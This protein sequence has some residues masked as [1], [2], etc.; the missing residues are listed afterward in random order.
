MSETF[1]HEAA[2]E[3]IPHEPGCYLMKDDRGR[4][5]YIGK[6]KD[7]NDRVHNYFQQSGDPRPFVA[8]LPMLLSDIDTIITSNEK[9]ALILE[10]T[11]IKR[12]Q[13]RFNVELKDDK[14][15]LSLRIDT[16]HEWP[17]V[18]VVRQQEDDGA[19]YFGPYSSAGAIRRTL[20][21]INK[22]FQL[23]SCPDTVLSN[24]DRPCLQHQI[25]RCPAPCVFALDRDEYMGQLEDAVMFLEGRGDDL[26][27]NIRTKMEEASED[28]E[29]ELAA[30]YRDQLHSIE[31]VLE[32][33]VAVNSQ[34]ID[35]DAIGYYREG[36]RLT[37][38]VVYL[39]DGRM[40]GA[41]SFNF[42]DQ[43]FPDEEILSSFLNQYYTGRSHIPK[44][45]LLPIEMSDSEQEAFEEILTDEAGHRVYIKTP[46]RGKKKALVET[47]M[48]NAEHSFESEHSEEE[49]KHDLMEKLQQGLS[50]NNF[51]ERIECYDISNLQGDQIVGS[52][53]YFERA[54]PE[55]SGYR[56][57]KIRDVDEQD[58]FASMRE[59]LM[60]R[61]RKVA[62]GEEDAPDLVVIDG[63]KGQ[64]AQASTVFEDLG[65]HRIDVIALAKSRTDRVGFEDPEVTQSPE[66]AF[67]PNRKNPIRLD[68]NSA[69]TYLLERL[70][71]EAHRF[72]I[73]YHKK[74]RRKETLKSSLDDVPG[75][76][77]KTKRDLLKHF[78]GLSKVKDAEIAELV[79]VDGVGES[80]AE[81]IRRYFNGPDV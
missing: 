51:P 54:E 33:Q 59:V 38:E 3:T 31:Q 45:V 55:K 14:N 43:E 69:E 81:T 44:E 22:H 29:F 37:I 57:Y 28:L 36:D 76:G 78:G 24:R 32:R 50:L 17:R 11:L 42:T 47:A 67:K 53:V 23:R 26:V 6:A 63:G 48:T 21:I 73:E 5:I 68:A 41:Q 7:L 25:G 64:L 79:E 56:H 80:T 9:E 8:R 1:D 61:F 52:K 40:E 74:L 72:A 16:D 19:L 2:L 60:R 66:R 4:V 46:K 75:V 13:P 39:R 15:F 70:R 71:D 35:T 18:E 77:T 34:D 20:K 10:N 27:E 62:E 58:D 65:L 49:Q 12:H 30:R